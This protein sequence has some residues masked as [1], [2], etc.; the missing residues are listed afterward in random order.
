LASHRASHRPQSQRWR[1]MIQRDAESREPR[2]A[3]V[4]HINDCQGKEKRRA[5]GQRGPR[6]FRISPD[7]QP[8]QEDCRFSA[9]HGYDA[10]RLGQRRGILR[11]RLARG[12]AKLGS[13]CHRVCSK[14]MEPRDARTDAAS[15][16][17]SVVDDRAPRW[18]AFRAQSQRATPRKTVVRAN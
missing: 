14:P 13:S 9:S 11:C 8:D 7:W 4:V 3:P 10:E 18:A 16:S 6:R 2:P 1:Q 5:G 12:V 15:R 17:P